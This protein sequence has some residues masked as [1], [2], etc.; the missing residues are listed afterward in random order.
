MNDDVQS[1]LGNKQNLMKKYYD[2]QSKRREEFN[3]NDS[4][5]IKEGRE[6]RPARI[7]D[8][9]NTPRSYVVQN[10]KII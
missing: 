9:C 8:K 6:W 1:A 7:I 2:K 10:E 5:L 4:V 3:S